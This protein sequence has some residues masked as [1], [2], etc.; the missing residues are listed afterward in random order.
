MKYIPFT[1]YK[2][3]FLI[4]ILISSWFFP[5]SPLSPLILPA[6][7]RNYLRGGVTYGPALKEIYEGRYREIFKTDGTR[8]CVKRTALRRAGGTTDYKYKFGWIKGMSVKILHL[9]NLRGIILAEWFPKLGRD[10]NKKKH[11][12]SPKYT[13]L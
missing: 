3:V 6:L 10:K 11:L 5:T 2:C 13:F 12:D 9:L 7:L 4:Y 1:H 8:A